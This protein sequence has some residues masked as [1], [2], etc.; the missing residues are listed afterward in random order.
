MPVHCGDIA[1]DWL[2]GPSVRLEAP[3]GTTVAVDPVSTA[4][5]IA[6]GEAP[7]DADLVCVTHVHHY[8][9]DAIE[10]VADSDATVVVYDAVHHSETD[11]DVT[12]VRDVEFE[13][14]RVDAETDELVGD[15]ILRTTAAYTLP[16]GPNVDDSGAPIHPEGTGCG[17][18]VHLGDVAAFVPGHTD[19]LAGHD[20]LSVDLFLPPIG[21]AGAMDPAAAAGLAAA[22]EP[23]L[24]VPIDYEPGR[25]RGH[26]FAGDV[27]GRGVP[28]VL[29]AR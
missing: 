16:D 27:A 26:E 24:V 6:S 12:P 23:D 8:D 4:D 10:A 1:V 19:V 29:D 11:R 15:V 21:A 28:V 18:F 20:E 13:T 5:A 3:D 17:L 9:P 14:R 7:A 25:G 22:L 2:G